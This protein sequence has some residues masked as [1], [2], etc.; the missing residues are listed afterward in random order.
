MDC[1]MTMI[2]TTRDTIVKH[3]LYNLTI[4]ITMDMDDGHGL[5][6]LQL[7]GRNPHTMVETDS[8]HRPLK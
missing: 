2:G 5:L 1:G 8:R 3:R 6:K 4:E 7:L